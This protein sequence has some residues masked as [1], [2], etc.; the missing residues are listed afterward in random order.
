V[1]PAR[2]PEL[3]IWRRFMFKSRRVTHEAANRSR[4]FHA[5]YGTLLNPRSTSASMRWSGS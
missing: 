5:D 3:Y 1:L 4:S 2:A